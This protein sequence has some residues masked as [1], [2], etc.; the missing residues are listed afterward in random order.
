MPPAKRLQTRARWT[1][2]FTGWL[3]RLAVGGGLLAGLF[4]HVDT[5]EMLR[6]VDRA[7]HG[8][9]WG[10][11]ALFLG[12]VVFSA[13]PWK[14][15]LGPPR[16]ALTWRDAIELSLMGFCL[17]NLIPGGLGGDALRAWAAAR[18]S[19]KPLPAVASVLLDRWLAFSCLV[20][21]AAGITA[22]FSGDLAE[23]GLLGA[24]LFTLAV[25][26][27]MFAV[28]LGLFW[29]GLQVGRRWFERF[30]MGAPAAGLFRSLAAYG[31][32]RSLLLGCLG[33]SAVT[34]L[35]DA[36]GF[37]LIARA[38]DLELAVWPFLL[39]IPVLRVIHHLPLSVNAFGTQDVAVVYFWSAFGVPEAE[40]L[41]MS[42]AG[43]ALKLLV[44][45]LSGAIYLLSWSGRLG[46]PPVET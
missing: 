18:Q 28:S 33:L 10:A 8:P 19:G 1:H 5:G 13:V 39:M 4:A 30:A 44:A 25:L 23:V 34:P 32:H 14:V 36:W 35:L 31:R 24:A 7:R 37:Y 3:L 11:I 45:L 20:L 16:V 15:L 2:R 38:L 43:H 46:L 12:G 42:L 6:A 41:V 22:V 17:N 29:G 9:L 21:L 26:L 40:A 27:A